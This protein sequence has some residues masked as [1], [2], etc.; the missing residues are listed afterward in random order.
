MSFNP[1]TSKQAQEVIFGRK[2]KVTALWGA[3]ASFNTK[4]K[5][6]TKL[7]KIILS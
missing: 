2:I 5:D 4:S 7:K 6:N 3:K 1:D